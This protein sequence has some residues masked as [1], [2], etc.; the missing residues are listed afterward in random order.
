[1]SNPK[2]HWDEADKDGSGQIIFSEFCD[3]AI[4]NNLYLDLNEDEEYHA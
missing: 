4:K 3:W 1:M 2:K